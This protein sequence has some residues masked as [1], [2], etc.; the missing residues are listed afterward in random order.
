MV[1]SMGA[2]SVLLFTQP[3]SSMSQP[4]ALVGGHLVSSS[5]GVMAA[6]LISDPALAAATAVAL[7]IAGMLAFRCLHPPGGAAALGAVLGGDSVTS[8]GFYYVLT[9]VLFNAIVLLCLAVIINNLYPGRRYPR[10][11][12]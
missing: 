9:P 12:F 3:N 2:A 10:R 11:R 6:L 1:A 8:L 4:W 7:A 5:A